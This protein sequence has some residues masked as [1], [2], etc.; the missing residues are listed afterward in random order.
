MLLPA[1]PT[2][3]WQL[4]MAKLSLVCLIECVANLSFAKSW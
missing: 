1:S 2:P 3:W 4:A